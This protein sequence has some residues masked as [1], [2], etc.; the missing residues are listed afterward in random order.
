MEQIK[1]L[2]T[3]VTPQDVEDAIVSEDYKKM[4]H[5]IMVCHLTL[6]DGF[7]V[8]GTA[9]VVNP[10]EYDPKVGKIVARSK[11][12]DKVWQHLGSILNHQRAE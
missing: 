12:M 7:E 9:G 10:D 4:G 2:G 6:K 8:I 5:K 3:G 11:A 1:I